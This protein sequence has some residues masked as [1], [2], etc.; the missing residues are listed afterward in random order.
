MK[1][2]IKLVFGVAFAA[3]AVMAASQSV[4]PETRSA[5]KIESK[6]ATCYS[7]TEVK[8]LMKSNHWSEQEAKTILDLACQ[9]SS[10]TK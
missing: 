8:I 6:S 5:V 2:R 7:D 9:F 10:R 3:A 4:G 1:T